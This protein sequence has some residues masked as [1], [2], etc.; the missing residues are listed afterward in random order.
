MRSR[1][2][3]VST[4]LRKVSTHS[5][6]PRDDP[7][8]QK[9]SHFPLGKRGSVSTSSGSTFFMTPP[10][11]RRKDHCSYSSVP[12]PGNTPPPGGNLNVDLLGRFSKPAS[13][14]I[15]AKTD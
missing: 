7:C 10:P 9:P 5:I 11:E 14:I 8:F 12:P 2:A 13:R 3:P 1:P 15:G 6:S 4:P